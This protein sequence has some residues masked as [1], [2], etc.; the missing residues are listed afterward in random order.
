MT[1][2]RQL[3]DDG[4]VHVVD[5]AMGTMLYQK[6]AFLNVCFD[7]LVVRQPAMVAEV[8]A[9]Y[10][11]A[12]SE[13]IETNTFGANPLKL[14]Q[15]GLAG[16]TEALNA[17]DFDRRKLAE[18]LISLA[19]SRQDGTSGFEQ[20]MAEDTEKKALCCLLFKSWFKPSDP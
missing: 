20:E 6:G 16:D 12:G 3:I 18:A 8:H 19:S 10:V 14:A 13:L 9:A 7:E 5:G 2:L 17:L 11:A 15:Y 1:T 4:R